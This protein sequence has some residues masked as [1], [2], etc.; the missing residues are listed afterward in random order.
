MKRKNITTSEE[1]RVKVFG[2]KGTPER[3]KYDRES[4]QFRLSVM[5]KN[6]RKSQGLTQQQ[7][8]DR[9]G[10]TKG[11]ISRIENSLNEVRFSTLR[12]IVEVG[13]GGH[14]DISFRFR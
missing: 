4:E 5:L 12:K 6:A 3:D 1:F 7:L 2:E 8:A 9:V 10:T 14:M 11:Y 13:L